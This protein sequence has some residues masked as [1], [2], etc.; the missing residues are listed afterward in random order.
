MTFTL[1]VDVCV[2]TNASHARFFIAALP[3][4]CQIEAREVVSYV[5][6]KLLIRLKQGILNA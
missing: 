1:Y 4:A 2:G 3:I 5:D 6:L